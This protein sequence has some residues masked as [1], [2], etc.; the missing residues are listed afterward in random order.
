MTNPFDQ[1]DTVP[2]WVRVGE[3]ILCVMIAPIILLGAILIPMFV[4]RMN[5][6]LHTTKEMR[7]GVVLFC[8]FTA[9]VGV[10]FLVIPRRS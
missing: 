10:L 2:W 4:E 6:H 1:P 7:T 9:V 8:I 3:L 5:A